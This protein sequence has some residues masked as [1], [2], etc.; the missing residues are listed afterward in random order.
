M[1]NLHKKWSALGLL[2]SVFGLLTVPA[3]AQDCFEGIGPV[4]TGTVPQ[5]FSG[6]VSG[7]TR[8]GSALQTSIVIG[9]PFAG[10]STG[11]ERG[12]INGPFAYHLLEPRAVNQ[13]AVSEGDFVDQI[14]ITWAE[15]FAGAQVKQFRLLRNG[16]TLGTF[17]A[18]VTE[19]IDQNV[20]A[21]R[22]YEYSIIALNDVGESLGRSLIGFVNPNGTVTGNIVTNSQRAVPEVEV[23]MTPTLGAALEFD[24]VDD[25][26][27]VVHSAKLVNA[28]F[29]VEAW[30]FPRGV[31][32]EY[33]PVL[34]KESAG[35]T[36]R[37][38]GLFFKPGTRV[39]EGSFYNGSKLITVES[40]VPVEE[41]AWSHV[42][43]TYDGAQLHL[44][45]NGVREASSAASGNPVV[46]TGS[47]FVGKVPGRYS[48]YAGLI[49]DIRIWKTARTA[50]QLLFSQRR[51]L[52][53][54]DT[55]AGL[56]AYWK[57]DENQ[58]NKLF[59]LTAN[60]H[61]GL[62]CGARFRTDR[63]PVSNAAFTD[64]DGNYVIDGINYGAGTTFTV[65]PAKITQIGR[66]IQ[67]NGGTEHLQI[68]GNLDL[69]AK[70]FTIEL[71]ARRNGN[72]R[73]QVLFTQLVNSGNAGLELGY[74]AENKLYLRMGTQTVVSENQV[75]DR[76]H[77][78]AATFAQNNRV[79]TL[80]VDGES[81]GTGTVPQAALLSS[82]AQ[83]G[84]AFGKP[85]TGADMFTGLL[86]DARIW[87]T[88]R[89]QADLQNFATKVLAGNADG[90]AA[91][92]RF[93]EGSRTFA[94][95]QTGRSNT[96]VFRGMTEENWAMEIPFREEFVHTFSPETRKVTL[97]P[98]NTAVNSVN[99][100]NTSLIKVS[101]YVRYFG[102][103]CF[104]DS[105]EMLV[106]GRP[107]SPP[108]FTDKTGKF[109]VEFEP[110][111]SA[112]ISPRFKDHEFV[113]AMY[114]VVNIAEPVANVVFDNMENRTVSGKIGGGACLNPIGK[115]FVTLRSTSGCFERTIE[116]DNAGMFSFAVVP[117]LVYTVTVDHP[118]PLVD[119]QMNGQ[120]IN[121]VDGDVSGM[122]FRYRAEPEVTVNWVTSE[123]KGSLRTIQ[124]L[125]REAVLFSINEMYVAGADTSFCP[126]DSGRI[127]LQNDAANGE[128]KT[129]NFKNGQA[130]YQFYG[131]KPNIL[132]PYTKNLS[133]TVTDDLGRNIIVAATIVV[134]GNLPEENRF[135]TTTPSVPF[136]I[137]HDPPGDNSFAYI[138][139]D[140]S[141][142][143][144]LSIGAARTQ[145][146]GLSSTVSM[147]LDF[148]FETG[149]GYSVETE[150]NLTADLESSVTAT[151]TNVS[152]SEQTISFTATEV[153]STSASDDML[154]GKPS[155][156]VG[157]D[158]DVYI[159]GAMNLLYGITNVLKVNEQGS[160]S[161][162]KDLIVV[163]EKFNTTFVYTEGFIKST[164]IPSLITVGDT[165][166]ADLWRSYIAKNALT[167]KNATFIKNLS[168]DAG[169]SI[170]QSET[171]EISSSVANEF[172][173]QIDESVAFSVGLEVNGVGTGNTV[174]TSWSFNTGRTSSQS[175]TKATTFGYTLA[176]NDQGDYFTVDV[177]KDQVYGSPVFNL[178]S[179]ASSCPHEPNTFAR[180]RAQLIVRPVK[181]VNVPP[182]EAAVFEV[183]VQNLNTTEYRDYAFTIDQS[184]NPF[185]AAFST[186]GSDV[187]GGVFEFGYGPGASNTVIIE[188][189]KGPLVSD[190]SGVNL[191]AG[192][193][194]SLNQSDTV[195]LAFNF[196]EA[197]SNIAISEPQ[198]G[199]AI[200]R[201]DPSKMPITF[202]D[203]DN[204]SGNVRE[205][206][207]QYRRVIIGG[208][209]KTNG[210]Q[211]KNNDWIDIEVI[212]GEALTG[213]F[214]VSEWD[215]SPL[216]D[217][218][219]EVRTVLSCFGSPVN[220]ASQVVRGVI[221]RNA[222][223]V[224]G[225]PEPA[226]GVFGPGDQIYVQFN[227]PIDPNGINPLTDI[228][229]INT[230]TGN[231]IDRE[232][233]VFSNAIGIVPKSEDRFLENRVLRVVINKI[234][235]MR[236]NEIENPIT[237][238]FLF[239]KSP[240]RWSNARVDL[241]S[242]LDQTPTFIRSFQNSGGTPMSF[243]LANLPSW[244]T[245]FPLSGTLAPGTSVDIRFNVSR[246]LGAG[247]YA[248][249]VRANTSLGNEPL[250]VQVR[251][252]CG[253]PGWTLDPT[254][255]SQSMNIVGEL[256]IN[257]EQ[258]DDD[259]DQVG[260]FVGNELRGLANVEFV[261]GL[262]K[263]Q[264]Y[265]TVY[266]NAATEGPLS[267]RVWDASACLEFGSIAE[268]YS[269]TANTL[270][271]TPQVPVRLSATQNI[272]Q[273]LK[274]NRGWTW[275]SLNTVS[276]NMSV[277]G[278]LR[279]AP[280]Q[281]GDLV[282]GQA[283]FSVFSNQSGW[284]GTLDTLRNGRMYQTNLKTAGEIVL[285]GR[286]LNLVRDSISLASGWNWLGY[287]PTF[288][289][290]TNEALRNLVAL[291]GDIIK[292]QTQFAVY[293][294]GTG[295]VGNL[296]A[297]APLRGYLLFT[298]NGGRF[299]YP[300]QPQQVNLA[301]K[302]K[303]GDDRPE[304]T[305][306]GSEPVPGS[307]WSVNPFGFQYSMNVI[308]DLGRG[309]VDTAAVLAAFVGD[310][311]RGVTK[312]VIVSNMNRSYL[313]LTVYSN[314]ENGETL[315][316]K[317]FDKTSSATLP[318]TVTLP[319]VSNQLAG[320]FDAPIV[321]LP[322]ATANEDVRDVPRSFELMQNY[323]NPFNGNT[324]IRYALP[325]RSEVTITVYNIIGQPVAVLVKGS[326]NAG[327]HQVTLNSSKLSSGTYVYEMRASGFRSVKKLVHLK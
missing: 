121:A 119:A 309:P 257:G 157:D 140:S 42:A 240:V 9:I 137:L 264:L 315:S 126:V 150:I 142:S 24:G 223:R 141:F 124:Q 43:L 265:A 108:V 6:T 253:G 85:Q 8:S 163:P 189:T 245:A 65:R 259:Y 177:K 111:V 20:V 75:D 261:P 120:E 12:I 144:S 277:G 37:S 56:V 155:P 66:A 325:E 206:R 88:V 326:Q 306:D 243:E 122:V 317:V 234:K 195:S 86:D 152:T 178:I 221:D 57:M 143:T 217:G 17:P 310:E 74:N 67:L 184:T 3:R 84:F 282:R 225:L 251:L 256:F 156:F 69:S 115:A 274:L 269:F 301:A 218:I 104:A 112:Q 171:T 160:V 132:A 170:S 99:F 154:P 316:F 47:L 275:F 297:M 117:P 23:R 322:T 147:G 179:G 87:T 60:N 10:E 260:F 303:P 278:I 272:V 222:P 305:K 130:L 172:S 2:F 158:G 7:L 159:G 254:A 230:E 180:D 196:L 16:S 212:P 125:K 14:V 293:V 295:W 283:G 153:I 165:K 211:I 38:Y 129:L 207:V 231:P 169:S 98:S 106:N 175:V 270:L 232:V 18:T 174:E 296:T 94:V 236:G 314:R 135:T 319:F 327:Y 291:N 92:W 28:Q 36:D 289:L 263:Y 96:A 27:G 187:A 244:L 181:T 284:V 110:G 298:R 62:L 59:D 11:G 229:L 266:S 54:A 41:L 134:E 13:F 149:F 313:F 51:A 176:D 128:R 255:F 29:S 91:Y 103:D 46:N 97:N 318:V 210:A 64:L 105:V 168:F 188:I 185:G 204:S 227:E 199:W 198:G 183:T 308:A 138:Q 114:E 302:A 25:A 33:A 312:P 63:A 323:P 214:R 39:L 72:D 197:C 148:S 49:D 267:V 320:S 202:Y 116:T 280:A 235:D 250:T 100:N 219:Y 173:L 58:G 249:V 205:V 167:K 21:G 279:D 30:V 164:L 192:S 34:V 80:Y 161:V 55:A 268:T 102:S 76:W 109:E 73:R 79:V 242:Y 304:E 220:S 193:L 70:P 216:G 82:A 1:K 151:K 273:P 228:L 258:S 44:Y 191:I 300:A 146:S 93:N 95:D 81:A 276:S 15:E 246:Q 271:G 213:D 22:Y 311:V 215:T 118:N 113:P 131:G 252:L 50:Q 182:D 201:D 186:N 286:P 53:A 68:S 294:P 71:W 324:V 208:A 139:R 52:A 26:F 136:M 194:C 239:D 226:S 127:V 166:S 123:Q 190:Y 32:Q 4:Q 290:N 35:T 77:H 248:A 90:L 241:V 237:W 292:S 321:L 145:A 238:E 101:G 224:L 288:S 107:V 262:N 281:P 19:F 162:H 61:D 200:T 233:A 40:R 31:P 89:T 299:V 133:A 247:S 203:Y 48:G 209:A 5:V 83:T 45:L 285:S 307:P 78:I 287:N